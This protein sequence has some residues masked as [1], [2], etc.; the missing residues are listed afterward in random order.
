MKRG[1]ELNIATL[2]IVILAVLALVIITLYFTGGMKGFWE[3]ITGK[4]K[5]QETTAYEEARKTC[6]MWCVAR[7]LDSFC[8][9][10]FDIKGE[11]LS[12]Y[13]SGIDAQTALE[14]R[15]AGYNREFCEEKYPT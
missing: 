4:Q 5:G 2:I 7:D 3:F 10:V 9:H 6:I 13:S 8:N 11:S 15:E 14:C 1:I 12:C